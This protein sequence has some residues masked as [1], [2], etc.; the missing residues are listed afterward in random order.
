MFSL[1]GIDL[2]SRQNPFME[3]FALVTMAIYLGFIHLLGLL[4]VGSLFSSVCRMV[5][6]GELLHIPA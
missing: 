6:L 5:L 4:I 1:A 3:A 2:K